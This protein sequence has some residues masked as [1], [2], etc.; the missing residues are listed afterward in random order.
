VIRAAA[1]VVLAF[2]GC[3]HGSQTVTVPDVTGLPRSAAQCAI[4]HAGLRWRDSGERRTSARARIC[5]PN[6]AVAPDP[7]IIPQGPPAGRRVLRGTT[8][9]L[10]DTCTRRRPCL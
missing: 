7:R 3:E 5:G 1:L 4:V 2:A 6:E 8:V 10:H 9:V